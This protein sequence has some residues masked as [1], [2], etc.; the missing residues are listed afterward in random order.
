MGSSLTD[1]LRLYRIHTAMAT[2]SVAGI[3]AYIAGGGPFLII[4]AVAGSILHHAWGFSLNEVVDLDVDRRN[5]DL[6]HKPLVSGRIS[7]GGGILASFIAL[8]LSFALFST[9]ALLEG[10]DV[11]IVMILLSASTLCGGIYDLWGKRFPLSDIFVSLWMGLLV[12]ASAAGVDGWDP[13]NLGVI[14]VAVLSLVHIL[15]NNS[16]EGGLKDVGNDA[17][18]GSRTL[19]VVTG[20][21]MKGKKLVVA[22]VFL[23]WSLLLRAS[24]VIG[25]AALVLFIAD[26]AG[27]GM[28]IVVVVSVLG[29]G[30][31]AHALTFLWAGREVERK[32]LLRTFSLHELASFGISLLVILPAAGILPAVIAFAA[33]VLWLLFFNRVIFGTGLAPKV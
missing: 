24:F 14:A 23:A 19:A 21:R 4:G 7:R 20:C 25:S 15:F 16:V 9:G 30:L 28:W 27:W 17:G 3:A 2:A 26:E 32:S 5:P 8:A 1:V 11:L 31:F 18:S 29:A 13:G 22:P 10:G 33:P 12:M 6:A